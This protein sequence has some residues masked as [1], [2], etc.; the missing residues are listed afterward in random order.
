MSTTGTTT[1]AMLYVRGVVETALDT[2]KWTLAT[3]DNPF[4][5][6]NVLM[7]PRNS[8]VAVISWK[9]DSVVS[10]SQDSLVIRARLAITICAR[11][12]LAD[13][14]T[15]KLQS[16]GESTDPRLFE[17]HDRIKGAML[18]ARLPSTVYPNAAN[19]YIMYA[20][21]TALTSPDGIPLDGI[22]QTWECTLKESF[23]PENLET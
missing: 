7:A 8:G 16:R 4:Q 20:G 14:A 3:A 18:H 15:M 23:S 21:S 9:S 13:Q 19:T 5:A 2:Y 12:E 6:W 17:I 11:A 10:Q 1:L 22:E